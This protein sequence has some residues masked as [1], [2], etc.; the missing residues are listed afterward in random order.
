MHASDLCLGL[1]LADYAEDGRENSPRAD[2]DGCD[3]EL[4]CLPVIRG[5]AVL[6]GSRAHDH[7][8]P[9]GAADSWQHAARMQRVSASAH[10]LVQDWS[11]RRS[12]AERTEAVTADNHHMLNLRD[13]A[14]G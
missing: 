5:D 10:E 7:R 3:V 6:F 12:K 9:V 8:S 11:I 2:R 14:L 1:V 13:C 4:V